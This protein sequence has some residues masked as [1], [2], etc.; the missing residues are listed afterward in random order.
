M[1][2]F[3]RQTP[4]ELACDEL[5]RHTEE[6]A[7]DRLRRC[8]RCTKSATLILTLDAE[9][10]YTVTGGACHASPRMGERALPFPR[11]GALPTTA[12][13]IAVHAIFHLLRA[14]TVLRLDGYLRSRKFKGTKLFEFV[15]QY[16]AIGDEPRIP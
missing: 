3:T 1:Q 15:A 10:R 9:L 11:S 2:N 16:L 14:R 7:L 6:I 5:R 8:E 12:T 13:V 4:A